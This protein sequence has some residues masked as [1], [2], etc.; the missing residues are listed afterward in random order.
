MVDA[1][2]TWGQPNPAGA[3]GVPAIG[4]R[5]AVAAGLL[6]YIPP[7]PEL[8]SAVAGKHV[9]VVGSG[10]SAMTAVIQLGEVVARGSV[11]DG[12]VGAAPRRDRRNLRRRCRRRTSPARC[13][14]GAIP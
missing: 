5:E 6:S 9:V 8:A 13:A 3:D 12:D 14:W 4:E 2:G 10:H 7:T 1:S 11:D